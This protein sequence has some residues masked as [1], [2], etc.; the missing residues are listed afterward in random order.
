MNAKQKVWENALRALGYV[1]SLKSGE[2]PRILAFY[3]PKNWQLEKQMICKSE[4]RNIAGTWNPNHSPLSLTP[5]HLHFKQ[6]PQAKLLCA[7][8]WSG[9]SHLTQPWGRC[10]FSSSR[11]RN[12]DSERL[13]NLP[14][15][16]KRDLGGRSIPFSLTNKVR[17]LAEPSART[18]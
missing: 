18:Q 10:Y 11:A 8:V 2:P 5:V 9:L 7:L 14:K 16:T 12:G 3:F 13:S 6:Q 17:V 4:K 15:A 1:C